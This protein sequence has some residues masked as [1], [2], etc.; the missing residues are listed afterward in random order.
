M[1]WSPGQVIVNDTGARVPEHT[2]NQPLPTVARIVWE[3]DGEEQFQTVALEWTGRDLYVPVTDARYPA[4]DRLGEGHL[5]TVRG[6]PRSGTADCGST[7]DYCPRGAAQRAGRSLLGVAS[8]VEKPGLVRE[9]DCLD[10]VAE[11]ELLEDMGDVGLDGGVA[12]VELS[13]DLGVGEASC[14]QPKNVELALGE[15][16]ELSGRRRMG[17]A[18]ELFDHAFGDGG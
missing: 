7:P 13:S 9:D 18:G 3:Q 5:P 15:I 16:V 8:V 10:A 11:V 1:A 12:D 6:C 14:D 4:V 17:H 2:F